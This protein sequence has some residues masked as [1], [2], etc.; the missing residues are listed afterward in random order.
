MVMFASKLLV[1]F[2]TFVFLL[3]FF[4]KA[5]FSPNETLIAE[6][7]LS[8]RLAEIRHSVNV[9]VLTLY[10]SM[11]VEDRNEVFAPLEPGFHHK[12]VGFA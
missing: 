11:P 8:Y 3:Q 5:I 1:F 4:Q 10:G 2:S 9:K 12:V 7:R 6:E